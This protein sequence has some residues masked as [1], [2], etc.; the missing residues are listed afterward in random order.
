VAVHPAEDRAGCDTGSPEPLL[1]GRR[2]S[3]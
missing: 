1:E 3:A 2:G